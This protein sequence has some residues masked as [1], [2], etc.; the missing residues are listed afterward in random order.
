MNHVQ[1]QIDSRIDIVTPENIAFEYRVAGP[2]RRLPAYLIDLTIRV[3]VFLVVFFGTTFALFSLGLGG[4]G[5]GASLAVWFVLEWFY[6]GLFETFWNGQTPGKRLLEIRVLSIEG[7]PINGMQGVLRNVLRAVDAQPMLPVVTGFFTLGLIAAGM[8]RRFQRLGDLAA[9]T[10][11]V[12]E[13]P[14]WFQGL[15]RIDEPAAMEL[16]RRIPGSF[17]ASRSLARALAAYVE[18]RARL[19]PGRRA[20]VAAHV[21]TPLRDRLGL[22]PDTDPDMLLCALYSRTFIAE[23][24][25]AETGNGQTPFAPP[26]P[27]PSPVPEPAS[28]VLVP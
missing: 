2:F 9:G 14:R 15:A 1:E 13:E 18:R 21:A 11:V 17:Q 25:P 26:A 19:A 24:L 4:L 5:V 20:E 27:A 23:R 28:P 6:G 12:I 22:P 7:Q 8:N 10:M 16:G 3:V